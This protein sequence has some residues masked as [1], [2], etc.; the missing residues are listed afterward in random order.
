MVGLNDA[1]VGGNVGL[2]ESVLLEA[3]T[4]F[5]PSIIHGHRDEYTPLYK[6]KMEKTHICNVMYNDDA[7]YF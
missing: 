4:T 6:Y 7:M 3:G 5:L 2:A 1:C